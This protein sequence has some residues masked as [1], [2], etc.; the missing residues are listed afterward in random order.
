MAK[1]THTKEQKKLWHRGRARKNETTFSAYRR[2]FREGNLRGA[3]TPAT[4]KKGITYR[5]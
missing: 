1:M 2:S 5:R 3:A 4:A